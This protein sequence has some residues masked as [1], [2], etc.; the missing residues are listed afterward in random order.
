MKNTKF[1]Q[2]IAKMQSVE[3]LI[4]E[5]YMLLD[6]ANFQVAMLVELWNLYF[7][8]G[9]HHLCQNIMTYC[10]TKNAFDQ[11][12][13]KVD[14][15]LLISIKDST[16]NVAPYAYFKNGVIELIDVIVGLQE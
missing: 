9:K 6:A 2:Q 15:T 14:P 12:V 3:K 10:K 8:E 5:K 4:A 11:L 1:T 7:D 13:P 16:G